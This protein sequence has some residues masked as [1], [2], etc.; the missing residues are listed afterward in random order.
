MHSLT[1]FRLG[2]KKG[3]PSESATSLSR[4]LNRPPNTEQALVA[5]AGC[6]GEAGSM[7]KFKQAG[8]RPIA[9]TGEIQAH[10]R[11]GAFWRIVD[12]QYRPALRHNIQF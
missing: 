9:D 4:D 3:A 5:G 10:N 2:R 12:S 8:E 11:R 7:T 1:E 6:Q